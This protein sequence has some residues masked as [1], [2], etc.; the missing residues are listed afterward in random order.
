MHFDHLASI[1]VAI[2]ILSLKSLALADAPA[3]QSSDPP[4]VHLSAEQDHKRLMDLLHI[5]SI[6]P[7]ADGSHPNYDESKANP[8]PTLPDP[9]ILNN[10]GKVTTPEMW[11]SLRRPEIVELFDRE[12]YGRDPKITPAVRWEI[13]S[14]TNDGKVITKRLAGHVDNSF[15]PDI[16]VTIGLTLSTPAN[17]KAPV[18]VMLQLL[19]YPF[20]GG[21]FGALSAAHRPGP[22]ASLQ[23]PVPI[24]FSFPVRPGSSRCW[25]RDGDMPC[26]TPPAFRLITGRGLRRESSACATRGSRARSDDWG[27]LKAWAWGA[28]RALDYF[29]T[30]PAVDATRVGVEGHSRWGKAALITMAYDQRFAI[31]YVSSSGEGGAK[32]NRRYWGELVENLT[33]SGEY[34]WMAGNFI[35]Y[36]GHWNDLPVDSHEM[37]ALCAPRPVLITGGTAPKGDGWVDAKGMFMAA[38]AAGPVYELLGKKDLGTTELPEL[39]TPLIDGDLAFQQHDGGHSDMYSWPT[40]ITF[41][42]RY[43]EKAGG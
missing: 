23:R 31:A 20:I 30:D 9:L 34:H 36:A 38:A 18:P 7:G 1:L 3:T 39:G 8:Y 17:A 21:R 27:V 16:T 22:G 42:S 13:L 6:P 33:G 41:A 32:L 37:I 28:S 43:F 40:F 35:K 29:Q 10:G 19:G 15:Y 2:L 24:P 12:V 11:W 14:Q 25:L 5:T 26:S 4:P